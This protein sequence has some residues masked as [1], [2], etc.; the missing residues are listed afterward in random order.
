MFIV[1]PTSVKMIVVPDITK[2]GVSLGSMVNITCEG[3]VGTIKSNEY[4]V[5]ASERVRERERKRERQRERQR[6]RHRERERETET[7]R[8]RERETET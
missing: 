3:N 6:E 8:Q 2:V 5:R 7:N 4:V 1:D